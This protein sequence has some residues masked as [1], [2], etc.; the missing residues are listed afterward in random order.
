MQ[1]RPTVLE[2]LD[3]VRSF[4]ESD[5]L[6]VLEGRRRFHTRVAANV[7]AIARRELHAGPAQLRDEWQRLTTLLGYGPTAGDPPADPDELRAAVARYTDELAARVRA[8][9][10]DGGTWRAAVLAHLRATAAEK[11]A[12][13]NPAYLVPAQ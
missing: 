6:P 5:L 7:L 12:I 11:L 1:D 2:L 9:E 13:A 3:A 8:G 10:A 4:L